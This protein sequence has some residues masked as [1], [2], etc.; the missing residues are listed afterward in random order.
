MERQIAR[1]TYWIGLLCVAVSLVWRAAMAVNLIQ[2]HMGGMWYSSFWKAGVVF[3]VVSVASVN[4]AWL[5]EKKE[6]KPAEKST[7]RA[8]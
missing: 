4:F 3:L 8:A 6:E 1:Y 5:Q 7:A 2:E